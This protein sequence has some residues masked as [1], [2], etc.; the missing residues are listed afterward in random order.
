M[1][2]AYAIRSVAFNLATAGLLLISGCRSVEDGPGALN[3]GGPSLSTLLLADRIRSEFA[4]PDTSA[5][6]TPSASWSDFTLGDTSPHAD[7]SYSDA[8]S[9]LGINV[10]TAMIGA[11]Q[12]PNA[13]SLYAS[14]RLKLADNRADDAFKDFE[15]G[16]ALDQN[17]AEL[18]RA[19]GDACV[20]LGRRNDALRSYEKAATL[21]LNEA[22]V[23][24]SIAIERMRVKAWDKAARNLISAITAPDFKQDSD[25]GVVTRA[26]L[27][28]ALSE[29][30]YLKAAESVLSEIA[31]T[32]FATLATS[33]YRA[34]LTEVF[35]RRS[36]IRVTCG[37][38]AL[39]RGEHEAALEHYRAAAALPTSDPLRIRLRIALAHLHAGRPAHAAQAVLNQISDEK[40]RNDPRIL[41][42][43]SSFTTIESIREDLSRAIRMT[44]LDGDL[45][46]S[47]RVGVLKCLLSESLDLEAQRDVLRTIVDLDPA[48]GS[49]ILNLIATFGGDETSELASE[50]ER[51]AERYPRHADVVATAAIAL[52]RGLNDII[53]ELDGTEDAGPSIVMASL[54]NAAGDPVRALDVILDI[55]GDSPIKSRAIAQFAHDAGDDFSAIQALE[56]PVGTDEESQRVRLGILTIKGD[57]RAAATC[58]REILGFSNT[59]SETIQLCKVLIESGDAKTAE[60]T[61]L[62]LI[63][64]DPHNEI[65]Y[66]MLVRLYAPGS[67]IADEGKLGTLARQ[68]RQH[69]DNGRIMRTIQ[70]QE[71]LNRSLWSQAEVIFTSLLEPSFESPVVLES[72]VMLWER[73]AKAEPEITARGEELLR[74]RI[75]DR[76]DSALLHLALARVLVAT[77]RAVEAESLL[78]SKIESIPF[79]EL[80]RQRERIL[81]EQL[82]KSDEA[83]RL[84]IARLSS[85]PKSINTALEWFDYHI[86]RGDPESAAT[87]FSDSLSQSSNI[88]IQIA[89]RLVA[90]LNKISPDTVVAR[91]RDAGRSIS[92]LC[93]RLVA[94]GAPLPAGLHVVRLEVLARTSPEDSIRLIR[95]TADFHA[96]QPEMLGAAANQMYRWISDASNPSIGLTYLRGLALAYPSA[97]LTGFIIQQTCVGGSVEDARRLLQEIGPLDN[98]REVLERVD[99]NVLK[100]DISDDHLRAE[101][102]YLIALE[103]SGRELV[104]DAR[105]LYRIALG[106]NPTH[107]WSANNLGFG[108]LESE[109]PT[110][111]AAR[112]IEIA[113]QS[114]PTE[115]SVIDSLAWLRFRQGRIETDAR[116]DGA[117][118]LIQRAVATEKEPSAEVLDHSGDIHWMAG[119]REKAI[120]YWSAAAA[121]SDADLQV[122]QQRG[123]TGARLDHS[124]AI[125]QRARTKADTARNGAEPLIER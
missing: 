18:H 88:S 105:K 19:M 27:G 16:L 7:T 10:A 2:H 98:L 4:K 76:P 85:A 31:S 64:R 90:A 25:L 117:L 51:I 73:A 5:R 95:A 29:L 55:D 30:G 74:R 68:M 1:P 61:L 60:S 89:T 111:D 101:L 65:P 33:R 13:V 110:D 70:A 11:S 84:I 120:E 103:F 37:D 118:A 91:G 34:E 122:L 112:L 121:R 12:D 14:G 81:R 43:L 17:S 58:A 46:H 119:M 94:T 109:G 28:V 108:L 75:Q 93:D 41:A 86:E 78:S 125:G 83:D 71:A 97:E 123:I 39:R 104:D 9:A 22:A 47:M 113:A 42:A 32:S 38:H 67:P 35:R 44:A 23:F 106:F 69:I 77:D 59:P 116:G 56:T 100:G 124:A 26:D 20:A 54:I 114:L 66:E 49:G 82:G 8:L 80:R 87:S 3:S 115:N 96:I 15:S 52:G 72:L 57:R 40:L 102:A 6:K 53:E 107:G 48:D 62:S 92:D 45:P 99:P 50:I 63:Q 24:R 79:P 21:G 36:D